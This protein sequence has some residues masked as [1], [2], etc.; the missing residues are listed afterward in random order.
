MTRN[1]SPHIARWEEVEICLR[2]EAIAPRSKSERERIVSKVKKRISTGL[3]VPK[4]RV[5]FEILQDQK[6]FLTS[7]TGH[8]SLESIGKRG[9]GKKNKTN[10][11]EATSGASI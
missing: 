3:K 9:K 4:S 11:T 6:S 2:Y 10:I 8:G 5:A 1:A 7:E